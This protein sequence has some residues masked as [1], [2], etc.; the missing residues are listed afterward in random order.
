MTQL[1]II[2]YHTVYDKHGDDSLMGLYVSGCTGSDTDQD[3]RLSVVP[4][5]SALQP[6]SMPYCPSDIL[7]LSFH[8]T[9]AI[10]VLVLN[11]LSGVVGVISVT[12]SQVM[13]FWC[14]YSTR[15]LITVQAQALGECRLLRKSCSSPLTHSP[16]KQ[17]WFKTAETHRSSLRHMESHYHQGMAHDVGPVQYWF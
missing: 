9:H 13:I 11:G 12:L 8:N 14:G 6:S 10:L 7:I 16:M 4:P 3:R 2:S 5:C 15:E 1:S 17:S